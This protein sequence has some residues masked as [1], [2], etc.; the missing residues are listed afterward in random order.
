MALVQSYPMKLL[1]DLLDMKT[2]SICFESYCLSRNSALYK[3]IW[4]QKRAVGGYHHLHRLLHL[5]WDW[6][7]PVFLWMKFFGILVLPLGMAS[8]SLVGSFML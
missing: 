4:A 7:G 6:R 8:K 3:Q 1:C 5:S 2:L